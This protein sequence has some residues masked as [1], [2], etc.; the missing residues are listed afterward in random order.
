[1]NKGAGAF[2]P[3]YS[4]N[5]ADGDGETA[6]KIVERMTSFRIGQRCWLG[7][8]ASTNTHATKANVVKL[9]SQTAGT[10][11]EA[12][13]S[14]SK[15]HTIASYPLDSVKAL[16]YMP[17]AKPEGWSFNGADRGTG[18]AG[19]VGT[20]ASLNAY[21]AAYGSGNGVY[22]DDRVSATL[23][24]LEVGL[25]ALTGGDTGILNNTHMS[26]N[27]IGYNADRMNVRWCPGWMVFHPTFTTSTSP[28]KIIANLEIETY[29]AWEFVPYPR[30]FAHLARTPS[31]MGRPD[32]RM[33][34]PTKDSLLQKGLNS[35]PA[36]GGKHRVGKP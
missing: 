30:T 15:A 10:H 20:T 14:G 2:F 27:A 16:E 8:T 29:T 32:A 25:H 12:L 22:P 23:A 35:K 5:D 26:D 18:T 17:F 7:G 24:P 9:C 6:I 13:D 21:A 36:P 1:M 3:I 28:E 4:V 19:Y 31:M 33:V 34:M 11:C